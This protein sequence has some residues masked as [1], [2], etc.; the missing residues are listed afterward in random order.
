RISHLTPHARSSAKARRATVELETSRWTSTLPRPR[1]WARPATWKSP[2]TSARRSHSLAGAIAASSSRRS[3]ESVGIAFER[4][5]TP[6]V[7]GAVAAVRTEAAGGDDTVAG[8]EDREV[9][10]RTEAPSRACCT[11]RAGEC[12]ELGVGDDFAAR[13]G[14]ERGRAAREE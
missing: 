2:E 5:Q 9:A 10:T 8:H 7:A 6:L 1:R 13:D 14:A 3:S 12:G 4:E 11:G